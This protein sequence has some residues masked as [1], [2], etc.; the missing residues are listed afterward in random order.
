MKAFREARAEVF[1]DFEKAGGPGGSTRR[2]S[3]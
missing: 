3:G 2:A 1:A